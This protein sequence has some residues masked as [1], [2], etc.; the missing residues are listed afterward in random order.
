MKCSSSNLWL[1]FM[2]SAHRC[3]IC[4]STFHYRSCYTLEHTGQNVS[5]GMDE[6][7]YCR[8]YVVYTHSIFSLL[9]MLFSW[10]ACS[11]FLPKLHLFHQLN[12]KVKEEF[13]IIFVS[14]DRSLED[15]NVYTEDNVSQF[16]CLPYAIATLPKLIASLKAHDMPHLVVID[17]DGTI[18]TKEGVDALTQDPT[19]KYFPW[20]PNRI[21]DLL[22]KNYVSNIDNT[23]S[24]SLSVHYSP[25]ID[26][27]EKY[28][29]LYFASHSDALAQEFT[30]WL[31]KAYNIL[32]KKRQDFE[33]SII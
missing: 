24:S 28:I 12:N 14:M 29:L 15:Y 27:D 26:L 30:P 16:W 31:V 3:H 18:I 32:K 21:V 17:K 25:T 22:P 4:C 1:M 8:R 2:Y 19:G 13:E 33:V 7:L 23:R 6:Y 5:F 20:R 11:K 9:S 10:T